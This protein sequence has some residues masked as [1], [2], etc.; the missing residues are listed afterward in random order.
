MHNGYFL[1]QGAKRILF[2]GTKILSKVFPRAADFG[3]AKSFQRSSWII[4]TNYEVMKGIADMVPT[5]ELSLF[6]HYIHTL[7]QYTPLRKVMNTLMAH[8][9]ALGTESVLDSESSGGRNVLWT[10]SKALCRRSI[11]AITCGVTAKPSPGWVHSGWGKE[12]GEVACL[13]LAPGVMFLKWALHQYHRVVSVPRLERYDE[14]FEAVP[15]SS[16]ALY[17]PRCV[18]VQRVCVCGIQCVTERASQSSKVTY[19][20]IYNSL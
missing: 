3:S 6:T 20:I 17:H 16:V 5:T 15:D 8:N 2:C 9:L 11:Q 12:Q 13:S 10:I 19:G 7:L 1:S 18:A 14:T 4:H